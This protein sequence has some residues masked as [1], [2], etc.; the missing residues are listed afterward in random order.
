MERKPDL[1]FPVDY[2]NTYDDIIGVLG[3]NA[4]GV[5]RLVAV[6][7]GRP[8]PIARVAAIDPE[9]VL[10]IGKADSFV[11]RV[12]TLKKSILPDYDTDT[13]EAAA[14]LQALWG[15]PD[16]KGRFGL[17]KI[18]IQLFVDQAPREAESAFIQRYAQRFGELPPLNRSA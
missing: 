15:H 16:A 8:F 10:Y 4:G 14:R 6:T 9:G 13:H 2:T 3:A 12:I 1:E 11:D 5:Y 7:D 17:Q 18:R